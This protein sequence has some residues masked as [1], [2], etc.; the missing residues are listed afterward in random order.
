MARRELGSRLV[1]VAETYFDIP[2]GA[3]QNPR[4]RNGRISR[5]RWAVAHVL[6]ET[7][8]WSEPRIGTLF[9]CDPS[10]IN[11]GK[12]RARELI[13]SDVLF[14]EGVERLQRE[15]TA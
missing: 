2:A 12:R 11:N 10:S 8:G 1:S 4:R 15:V 7:A 5:A 6:A 3:V 13:R 9:N 14:F